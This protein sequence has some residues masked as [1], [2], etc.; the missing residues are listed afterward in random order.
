MTD[1]LLNGGR[2]LEKIENGKFLMEQLVFEWEMMLEDEFICNIDM[3]E[4]PEFAREFDIQEL[5]RVFDNLASNVK[6][7]AD[8]KYP[9]ELTVSKK[10]EFLVI[11]QTNRLRKE[12]TEVESN[13][14]GLESIRKIVGHYKGDM[15]IEQSTEFFRIT[16]QISL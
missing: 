5:R 9:V 16:L 1:R 6:K 3:T 12:I 8:A 2:A 15:H 10:E 14:I 11:H 4:C 7:Y 13:G